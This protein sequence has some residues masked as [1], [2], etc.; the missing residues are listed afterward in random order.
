MSFKADI[1]SDIYSVFFNDAEFADYHR[2]EGKAIPCVLDSDKGQ[3]KSDGSMYDLAEADFILIAKSSDL[4][5]RKE[6][7]ALLNLDGREL[8]ISYWDEQSGVAVI[9]LY[10]AVTA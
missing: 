4:P 3:A 5:P 2:V 10:S 7:G 6:A 9:G 8:T 1:E